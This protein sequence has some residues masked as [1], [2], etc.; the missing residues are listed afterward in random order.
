MNEGRQHAF[1]LEVWF[2]TNKTFESCIYAAFAALSFPEESFWCVMKNGHY[3]FFTYLGKIKN[4]RVFQST[5]IC[6]ESDLS[7]EIL[8]TAIAL[9]GP[10]GGGAS[11]GL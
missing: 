11:N 9:L 5:R 1:P 7:P 6:Q 4:R 8:K 10:F 3:V 2:D